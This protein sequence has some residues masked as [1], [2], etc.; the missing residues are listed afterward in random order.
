MLGVLAATALPRLRFD[1]DPISLL[2]PRAE[3]V[4]TFRD[5][6]KDPNNSAYEVDVLAPSLGRR[7]SSQSDCRRYLK[8]TTPSHSRLSSRMTRMPSWS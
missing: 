1:P 6:A 7:K 8:W 3:T 4:V 2:D 5:L